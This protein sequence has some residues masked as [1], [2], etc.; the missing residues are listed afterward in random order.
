MKRDW[1]SWVLLAVSSLAILLMSCNSMLDK[2]VPVTAPPRAVAYMDGDPNEYAEL[3]GF[4]SLWKLRNLQTEVEIKHR[5]HIVEFN[6]MVADEE[7]EYGDATGPLALAIQEG[8]TA[9]DLL[10]GS[11]EQPFSLL[12]LMALS[13]VGGGALLLGKNKFSKTGDVP[14]TQYRLDI[15]AAV[16]AGKKLAIEELAALHDAAKTTV[17]NT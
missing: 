11:P 7:I 14:E 13:G 3:W 17:T 15:D 4:T 8:E 12:G 10:I 2:F 1:K 6:R 16:A 9:K 5:A